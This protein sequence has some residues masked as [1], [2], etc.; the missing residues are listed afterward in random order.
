MMSIEHLRYFQF[1]AYLFNEIR[2]KI[3]KIMNFINQNNKR[4]ESEF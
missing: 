4:C 2:I 1:Y 3:E